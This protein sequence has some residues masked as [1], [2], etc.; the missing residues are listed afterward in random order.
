[1]DAGQA[2]NVEVYGGRIVR[3]IVSQVIEN[4][5]IVVSQKEWSDSK[6]EGRPAIGVGY[7]REKVFPLSE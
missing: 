1:M 4:K 2:V 6:D 3:R 7:D 5:I